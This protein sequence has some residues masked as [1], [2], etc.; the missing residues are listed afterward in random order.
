MLW[1][2]MT[3]LDPSKRGKD[4]ILPKPSISSS[5]IKVDVR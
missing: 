5:M 2:M 1:I 3:V 4:G